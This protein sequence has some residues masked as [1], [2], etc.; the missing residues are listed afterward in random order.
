MA[1]APIR[2]GTKL[3]RLP[4][5]LLFTPEIAAAESALAPL[6]KESPL[7]E[8]TLLAAHLVELR[9][10]RRRQKEQEQVG[11]LAAALSAA[12]QEKL[13]EQ[14]DFLAAEKGKAQ[15]VGWWKH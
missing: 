15:K 14:V 4:R 13:Q 8:W 1:R 11:C 12:E 3:L 7:D 6:L 5:A 10:A 9:A 2:K